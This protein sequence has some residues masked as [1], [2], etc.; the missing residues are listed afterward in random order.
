V[1]LPN[2]GSG[3]LVGINGFLGFL[4]VPEAYV[5]NAALSDSMTFNNATCA[6]LGVTPDTYVWTWGLDYRT[7][8][9]RSSS[10][11]LGCP[12]AAQPFLCSVALCSAWLLCG[13]SWVAKEAKF[14][15]RAANRRF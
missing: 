12:M 3:D 5:S 15:N 7:R 14:R 6:S 2:T 4:F 11:G 8:T 9:S 10:E 1:F 13:A